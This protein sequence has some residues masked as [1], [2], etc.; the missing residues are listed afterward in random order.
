MK[1]IFITGA[2]RGIGR[3]TARAFARLAKVP[4]VQSKDSVLP[5]EA[6][7][8]KEKI[9][10]SLT[11][12]RSPKAL[13]ELQAELEASGIPTLRFVGDISEET[14]VKNCFEEAQNRFG[15]VDVLVNN[16]GI[17]WYGLL[18][19]M[20]VAEWDRLMAVN[21]RAAFLT[22]REAIPQMLTRHG[23]SIVNV[24][25]I[26]GQ[27][28][29][30]CEAAYAAT[31]GGINALTRSLAKELGPSGIRVNAAAF[32]MID[33]KMNDIFTD[34]EKAAIAEE[35]PLGRSAS[36]AEAAALLVDLALSHP[37]LT[38]QIIT[39]DGGWI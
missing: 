23:G 32:G 17:D 20:T 8:E 2:S 14:F 34:G 19:D 13:A 15:P 33:T 10:L 29:A 5:A 21:L 25:S 26:W 36:P 22:C 24:S 11:G 31:K 18:Q 3:E 16:A 28:G 38:G 12:F 39:L 6:F 7:A 37:Y 27:A 1:H 9:A 35:I 4:G 30:A